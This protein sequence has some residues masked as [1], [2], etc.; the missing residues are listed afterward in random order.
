M[1]R[2]QE[3]MRLQ[4]AASGHSGWRTLAPGLDALR[5]HGNSIFLLPLPWRTLQSSLAESALVTHHS[6]CWRPDFAGVSC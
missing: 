3:F 1:T 5:Q 6:L 4:L 2:P